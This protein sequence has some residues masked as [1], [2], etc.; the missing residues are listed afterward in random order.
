MVLTQPHVLSPPSLAQLDKKVDAQGAA[1]ANAAEEKRVLE[2][3]LFVLGR[4]AAELQRQLDAAVAT[5]NGEAADRADAVARCR[6]LEAD[7]DQLRVRA[8]AQDSAIVKLKEYQD[9][10]EDRLRELMG[11]V[12][13]PR[14]EVEALQAQLD[15]EKATSVQAREELEVRKQQA[16]ALKDQLQEVTASIEAMMAAKMRASQSLDHPE[17]LILQGGEVGEADEAGE[18]GAAPGGGAGASVYLSSRSL[19][20]MELAA[21]G[22]AADLTIEQAAR[23][24]KTAWLQKAAAPWAGA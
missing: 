21:A 22:A 7:R 5:A 13:V 15:R 1:L 14:S 23:A 19:S 10:V 11:A 6:A 20:E 4:E 18:E 2:S 3:R 16:S 9:D 8:D 12:G 17:V 24:S